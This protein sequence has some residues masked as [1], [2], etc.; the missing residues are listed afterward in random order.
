[1]ENAN[2]P[3]FLFFFIQKTFFS[4]YYY[5]TSSNKNLPVIKL[6]C[7]HT[8]CSQIKISDFIN[9]IAFMWTHQ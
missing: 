2:N 5:F 1:M 6:A 8:F 7:L 3:P 4:L 9:L